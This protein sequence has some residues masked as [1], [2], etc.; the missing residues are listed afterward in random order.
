MCNSFWWILFAASVSS[1]PSLCLCLCL[2]SKMRDFVYGLFGW[3]LTDVYVLLQGTLTMMNFLK[4]GRVFLHMIEGIVTELLYKR[5]R[6]CWC[7]VWRNAPLTLCFIRLP[8][9]MIRSVFVIWVN[10]DHAKYSYGPELAECCMM[11]KRWEMWADYY[12][13]GY[14]TRANT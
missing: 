1:S 9:I 7:C 11:K 10:W 2:C 12:C 8:L 6:F 13:Q 5:C 4:N 14:L 3:I